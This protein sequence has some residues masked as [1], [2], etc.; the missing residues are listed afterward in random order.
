MARKTR[1][2]YGNPAMGGLA[3]E[4]DVDSGAQV[5]SEPAWQSIFDDPVLSRP[6]APG[7]P[8]DVPAGGD[9][10]LDI[11]WDRFEQLLVFV[12]QGVVGLNQVRF[13]RYG[14]SGQAQRGIDLAGRHPDGTYTV[15]QCKQYETFTPADLRK[16]VEK[17]TKGKG[18][19]GARHLI[20]AVSTDTR[21]TEVVDEFA[22]LQDEHSDLG[23]ELWGAEQI[24]DVLR[25]RADI[26]GRFWTRET[27]ETF[28]TGAPLPGVAAA[29]PNWI[30]VADQILL[31]PL[32]VDGLSDQLADADSL[33]AV[34]PGVAA[35]TYGRLADTLAADGYSGHAYVMRRLSSTTS[36]IK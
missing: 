16:A 7:P 27:A 24:N 1:P 30:R 9:L 3:D 5:G 31:S 15:V 2:V 4:A 17:F 23:I 11:G 6:P 29:P 32:G 19:F 13:R 21:R 14:V 26:V 18:P 28:C 36:R 33:R 22:H 35:A 10:R 20:I 25:D 8:G 34:Q 12:A